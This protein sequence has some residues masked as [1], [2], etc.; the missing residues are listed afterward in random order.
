M[1]AMKRLIPVNSLQK[2]DIRKFFSCVHDTHQGGSPY[3][4]VSNFRLGTTEYENRGHN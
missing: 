1:I 4:K 3:E 2:N